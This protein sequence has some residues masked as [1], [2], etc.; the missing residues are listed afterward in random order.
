MRPYLFVAALL[1]GTIPAFGQNCDIKSLMT[2]K[3]VR[4]AMSTAKADTMQDGHEH[5]IVVT[6]TAVQSQSDHNDFQ[7]KLQVPLDT[8][9]YFHT[10][11]MSGYDQPSNTDIVNFVAVR[12]KIPGI[13]AYVLGHNEHM[14]V[15]WEIFPTGKIQQVS[16]F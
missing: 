2:R 12:K 14:W 13:C 16:F 3:D 7:I 15:V 1:L 6:A 9:A 10:H 5:G 4:D 11:P 8:V